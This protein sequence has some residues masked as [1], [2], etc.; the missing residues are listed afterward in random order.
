MPSRRYSAWNRSLSTK[1][2]LLAQEI[3]QA[4]GDPE[5]MVSEVMHDL[6]RFCLQHQWLAPEVRLARLPQPTAGQRE[7][8][9]A[10]GLHLPEAVCVPSKPTVNL[11]Y[12]LKSLRYPHFWPPII[13]NCRPKNTP[14]LGDLFGPGA[15]GLKG[16]SLIFR[17]GLRLR[18]PGRGPAGAEETGSPS[19]LRPGSLP[20]SVA[21][22]SG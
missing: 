4:I 19:G 14:G 22:P 20:G 10:L 12:C 21:A 8:L 5:V 15:W 18:S 3:D 17:S 16:E 11:S 9:Q 7:Y 2:A 13:W 1:T 6:D